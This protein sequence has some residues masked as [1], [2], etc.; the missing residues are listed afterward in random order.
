MRSKEIRDVVVR[1]MK[2]DWFNT[3]SSSDLQGTVEAEALQMA[4]DWDEAMEIADEIIEQ[5]YKEVEKE[6]MEE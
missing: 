6:R 3:M 2:E 5:I 1:A 4:K